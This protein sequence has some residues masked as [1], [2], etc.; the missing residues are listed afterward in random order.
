M[1]RLRLLVLG[2]F[3]LATGSDLHVRHVA[4]ALAA[5]GNAVDAV[6][7][8]PSDRVAIAA[9]VQAAWQFPGVVVS[10]GSLGADSDD[11]V[12]ATVAA[13]QD[14][15]EEVG[16]ARLPERSGTGFLEC[17]NIVFFH[18]SPERAHAVFD[19]WFAE[20][21]NGPSGGGSADAREVI[22]W[23]LPESAAAKAARATVKHEFP[24]V[25]QRIVPAGAGRLHLSFTG[26]SKGRTQAARKALQRLLSAGTDN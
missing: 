9:V 23:Q 19:A 12:R 17:G 4:Q 6:S 20:R 15:R 5:R 13:L 11:H 14:G 3:A 22:A 18:G 1:D 10:F 24:N 16:L 26:A 8:V 25:I 21:V 2:D 7:F